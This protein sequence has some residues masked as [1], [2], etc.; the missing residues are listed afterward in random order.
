MVLD[1][2]TGRHGLAVDQ[3]SLDMTLDRFHRGEVA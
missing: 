2:A 3:K 1:D